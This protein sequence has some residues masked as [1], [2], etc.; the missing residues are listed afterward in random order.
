M[1]HS[2]NDFF[3][4]ACTAAR[5]AADILRRHYGNQ[6]DIS[7]KGRIDLVTNADIESEKAIVATIRERWPDHD[8]ITEETPPDLRGSR[9]RWVIDPL[10]G[11]VNYAHD[12]PFFAVSIGFEIDGEIEMGVVY[13]PVLEEFFHAMKGKGAFLNDRPV[14]V[15]DT[16]ELD[17]AFL[18]TGFSYD[19]RE[20]G[21]N[22]DHF[23]HFIRNAQSVRRFGSAAIDMCYCAMGRFDGYWEPTIMPWDIAAG[24]II[25][26][27]AGGRVTKLD[28]SDLSIYDREVL[29]S[30]GKIHDT[31]I[32]EIALN[33]CQDR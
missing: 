24:K 29:A 30:N 28:G 12:I 6:K 17:R 21:E 7:Y 3:A 22:L 15:S 20:T 31:L 14:K 9:Y 26:G 16:A 5:T 19:V 23:V 8:I 13:N 32:R 1:E 33:N 4:T 2:R 10:D 25:V 18:V 11:T 27:E